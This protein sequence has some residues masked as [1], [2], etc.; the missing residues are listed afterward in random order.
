GAVSTG[1][2]VMSFVLVFTSTVDTELSPLLATKTVFP[3]RVI[4]CGSGLGPTGISMG[5]FVLVLTSIVET[6]S[7]TRLPTKAVLPSGVT[8]IPSG[9]ESTGM[10]VG[11][12]LLV[13]TSTVDTVRLPVLATKAVDRHRARAATADTPSGNTPISAPANP[14]AT[15]TRPHR[16]TTPCLAIHLGHR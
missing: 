13:F 7:P 3:S 11:F 14:S 6:V 10:S 16:I 15:T 4:A 1:M 12:L 8:T 9:N 5:F 2:S